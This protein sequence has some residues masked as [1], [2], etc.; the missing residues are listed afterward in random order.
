VQL[1]MTDILIF[2]EQVM[3]ELLSTKCFKSMIGEVRCIENK[4]FQYPIHFYRIEKNGFKVMKLDE[5]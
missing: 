1:E 2:L 3:K 5:L 4:F